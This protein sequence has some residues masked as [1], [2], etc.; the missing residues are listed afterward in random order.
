MRERE[1]ERALW[2]GDLFHP[3]DDD[4]TPIHVASKTEMWSSQLKKMFLQ[5]NL[6][7]LV[8]AQQAKT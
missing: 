6:A 4:S 8:N 2:A 1:R 5:F 3:D 7:L